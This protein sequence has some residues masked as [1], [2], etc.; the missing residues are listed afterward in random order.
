MGVAGV[1]AAEQGFQRQ[2]GAGGRFDG[3]DV[4]RPD[5]G[6]GALGGSYNF[7]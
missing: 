2:A 7:V 3:D 1:L 6:V 4:D 5:K